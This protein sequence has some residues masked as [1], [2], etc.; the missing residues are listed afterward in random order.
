MNILIRVDS[1]IDIGSGHL[2]RCLSLAKKLKDNNHIVTFVCKKLPGSM[3]SYIDSLGYV[4]KEIECPHTNQIEDANKTIDKIKELSGVLDW[5]IVDNYSLDSTWQGLLSDYSKKIMVIDDLADRNHNCDLLLDQN[6]YIN[7]AERY[8]NLVPKN[9]ITLLGPSHILLRDEFHNFSKLNRI[10]DGNISNILIFFGAGD[11]L[12]LTMIALRA[13]MFL[14]L[15]KITI[16]VV[17]GEINPHRNEVKEFCNKSKNVKLHYQVSNMAQLIN[18]A[19]LSIG[20]G[21]S[22][23]WERCYLGLPTLTVIFANNQKQTTLDTAKAGAIYYL[24]LSSELEEKDYIEAINFMLSNPLVVKRISDIARK[25]Y[26]P[27]NKSIVDV[28]E[29]VME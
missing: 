6:F 20:A 14:S 15:A 5:V 3:V 28:M 11:P 26:S 27:P 2:M 18:C 16:N 17:L 21:G 13:L 1:S 25:I 7:S 9:C 29:S 19:D 4:F 24:G 23:M 22:S 8:K 10:R 12:N